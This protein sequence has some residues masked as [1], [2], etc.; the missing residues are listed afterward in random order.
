MD[1]N[2]QGAEG[3][4][5]LPAGLSI[6][7]RTIA[8]MIRRRKVRLLAIA[9]VNHLSRDAYVSSRSIEAHI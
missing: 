5:M 2:T 7:R 4:R 3:G 6:A 8:H 9:G 1:A